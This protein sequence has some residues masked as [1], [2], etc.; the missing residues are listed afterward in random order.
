MHPARFANDQVG[1]EMDSLCVWGGGGGGGATVQCNMSLI[2]V[3]GLKECY[4]IGMQLNASKKNGPVF[5]MGRFK[6]QSFN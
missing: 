6:N 2:L 4:T 5:L 3:K 1:G